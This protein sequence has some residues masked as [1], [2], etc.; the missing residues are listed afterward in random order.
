MNR[1]APRPVP[2]QRIT[3]SDPDEPIGVPCYEGPASEVGR[4]LVP[5][6]Y[7]AH[8]Y[9]DTEQRYTLIV[10]A[11]EMGKD[12]T[13]KDLDAD[14]DTCRRALK[15]VTELARRIKSWPVQTPAAISPYLEDILTDA[16]ISES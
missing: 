15:R 9:G 4:F 3:V 12:C 10:A 14:H 8:D 1:S 2:G 5:G 6:T 11:G 16:G 7:A 13:M